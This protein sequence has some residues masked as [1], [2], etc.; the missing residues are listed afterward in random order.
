MTDRTWICP[1][2]GRDDLT[3]PDHVCAECEETR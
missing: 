2:C 3:S 1:D